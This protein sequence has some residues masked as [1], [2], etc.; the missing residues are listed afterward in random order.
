MYGLGLGVTNPMPEVG[1]PSPSSPPARVLQMP[2]VQIGNR[3]ATVT[4]AGLTPGLA[5]VYQVNAIVPAGLTGGLHPVAWMG[6]EGTI[7]S[8]SIA[9]K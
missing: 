3:D 5:G 1:L 8:S 2:R 6:P 9:V 7:S 4:F